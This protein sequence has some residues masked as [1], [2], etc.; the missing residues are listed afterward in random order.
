MAWRGCAVRSSGHMW[1]TYWVSGS[2]GTGGAKGKECQGL[3]RLGGLGA[4]R[5]Q[6]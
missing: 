1:G 2:L 6:T 3:P 5:A 4:G